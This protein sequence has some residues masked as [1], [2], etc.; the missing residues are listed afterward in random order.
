MR[1][2]SS[3]EKRRR[4]TAYVLD[5]LSAGAFPGRISVS[6]SL[7]ISYDEQ[8]SS[9]TQ[10]LQIVPQVLKSLQVNFSS[11]YIPLRIFG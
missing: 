10:R 8:K 9:S 3:D 7:L 6:S 5:N 2:F 4:V 11:T 1:I